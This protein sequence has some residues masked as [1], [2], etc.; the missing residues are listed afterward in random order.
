LV[1]PGGEAF[2]PDASVRLNIVGHSEKLEEVGA[3]Q[4]AIYTDSLMRYYNINST[5]NSSYLNRA[6][7]MGCKNQALSES[8]ANQLYTRKYLRGTS[9]TG[10]LGDMHINKDG[11]KV[12]SDKDQKIIHRWNYKFEKSTWTTE[13]SKNVGDVLDSLK[14]GLDN[15]TTPDSLMHTDI[16]KS[17]GHG[18]TKTAYTLKD[19]P[20][21]L[22]LQLDESLENAN[23]VRQLK[24]EIEWINKF[25]ELGIKTPKY[26]KVVSMID[27][28]DQEHQGILVERIHNSTMVRPGRLSVP[29]E[30][31][32][33]KT[34]SD[35]QNLLQK[36]DL[37]HGNN[38][39]IFWRFNAQFSK[40]VNPLNFV[41]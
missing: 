32:T 25:R 15:K 12:M 21:L 14:L 31:V 11:S 22:F 37:N 35:I 6:A 27:G 41:F 8:Y 20:D 9:V 36:F 26:F 17:I 39:K 4:L 3:Q 24:N 18:S 7:L 38:L 23:S 19:H 34:L 10:R 33:H 1:F 28:D 2:T 13:S 5:D 29:E 40:F 16:G 30:R